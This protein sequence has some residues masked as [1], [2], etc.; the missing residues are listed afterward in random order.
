MALPLQ[1]QLADADIYDFS[2]LQREMIPSIVRSE[3]S[4]RATP[5][6]MVLVGRNRYCFWNVTKGEY[7]GRSMNHKHGIKSL[8]AVLETLHL[9]NFGHTVVQRNNYSKC[10]ISPA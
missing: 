9:H 6:R 4:K 5:L 7:Q 10:L 2:E 1:K 8:G 3:G